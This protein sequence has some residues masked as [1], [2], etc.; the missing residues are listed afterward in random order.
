MGP[1]PTA[2]QA[3]GA[4]CRVLQA[5]ECTGR[6]SHAATQ[7]PQSHALAL[8]P[9]QAAPGPP[10]TSSCPP[11][12]PAVPST[13]RPRV[14]DPLFA[15]DLVVVGLLWGRLCPC[16]TSG[17]SGSVFDTRVQSWGKDLGAAHSCLRFF[18]SWGTTARSIL[19]PW[20]QAPANGI[21]VPGQVQTPLCGGGIP[22]L[23]EGPGSPTYSC[24]MV[25]CP[26]ISQY[27]SSTYCIQV[28]ALPGAG[29]SENRQEERPHEQMW[30][31]RSP[32]SW[33]PGHGPS[34]EPACGHGER[35]SP[36]QSLFLWRP[37]QTLPGRGLPGPAAAYPR[38]AAR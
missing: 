29:P 35:S 20:G 10:G 33:T 34:P 8:C 18:R 12:C 11:S 22:C 31:P 38:T 25:Y 14:S 28:L 24:A 16:C 4:L 36:A 17:G 6:S 27:L 3:H 5:P 21:S 13:T 15:C 1:R 7:A 37:G 2:L 30:V 23:Q 9:P 32:A 19:L 26:P